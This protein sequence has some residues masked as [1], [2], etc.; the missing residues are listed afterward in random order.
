MSGR[1]PEKS[2]AAQALLQKRLQR[3]AAGAAPS[4][5]IPQRP[6]GGPAPVSHAQE[7][8]WFLDRLEPGSAAYNIPAAVRWHGRLRV[9]VLLAALGEIV[10]RHES[11]RTTF[12]ASESG[13]ALQVVSPASPPALPLI[14]L[15]ALAMEL[16]TAESGRLAGAEARAPFDLERGPLLRARLLRL[17]QGEEETEHVLLATLHHIVSDGWSQGLLIGELAALYGAFAAGRSSPLPE[18]T[19][20]YPDF[21]AWQR[22]WL[23]GEVLE[24]QLAYWRRQLAGAPSLLELPTDRPR[25]ALQ[26]SGGGSV[27]L[28]LPAGLE[29]AVAAL[30][31]QAGASPF[32]VLLA[33]FQALLGRVSGQEDVPVGTP[34]AGRTR[35]ETEPLIGLFMNTL[36][37][38]TDLSG[39]PGF[40]ELVG[41]VRETALEAFAHQDVPFEK[42]VEELRP[43]RNLAHSP[44]FQVMLILQNAPTGVV[45][46][47]DLSLSRLPVESGTAKLDLTLALAEGQGLRAQL[48]YRTDLFDRTTVLRLLGHFEVLLRA[49][50]A[51][52]GQRLSGLPLL[53]GPERQ[54]LVEWNDT[55]TS[56]PEGEACLHRLIEAQVER[57]PDAVAVV[58]AGERLT[59]R[60]LDRRANHL[61]WRLCEL[62]VEPEVPVGIYLDRSL[63][64][65]VALLA[66]WKAGG[67]YVPLDP[68]YPR[69][70]LAYMLDDSGAPVV[71]TEPGLLSTVPESAARAVCLE[72]GERA[73]GPAGPTHP[74]SLAYILYTSGSTGRPKGVQI[75]HGALVKFLESMRERPGLGVSDRLLAVT[76]LS[77]DIAG[78]ELFLPLLVGAEVEIAS[79]ET[80]ADGRRLL[81]RLDTATVLQ[82]TPSTWRLLLDSGWQGGRTLKAL[83]GGEALPP[84]L[85]AEISARAGSLWNMY[86]PT[87]T[88]IWSAVHR[89][90]SEAGEGTAVPLGTPI[91]NTT[92]HVVDPHLRPVPIGV[93]GEL[94]IG[95]AGLARG[96]FGRPDLTAER[97]IPDPFSGPGARLYRT[98]DLARWRA[99]GELEFLGRLDHQVKVRGHRIEL[100]EIEA[101][102]AR[103]ASVR[104]ALV[105][106]REDVPGD[107]RLTAFVVGPE[108]T[109]QDD[110]RAYLRAALPEYMVPAAFVILE[111]LPLLPNGKVDRKA[112]LRSAPAAIPR[113]V[114][115]ALPRTA[116]EREIAGIWREVLSL[117][118][119]GVQ[120]NFFDLGGHSLLLV[121]VQ[122]RLR[123]T[124]G[125]D[126]PLVDLFR[127]PTVASLAGYLSPEVSPE[128]SPE[129]A[130]PRPA[131][132]GSEIAVIGMAG[133]FP[134][135]AS[136]AELWRKLC[137]GVELI[138]SFSAEEGL[139]AGLPPEVVHDPR[140]VGARGVLEGPELFDA[141]F[142]DYTPREAQIMDP[143]QRV[144]LETAWQ[145]LEDAGY[146]GTAWPGR[147]GVY[148]GASE[149]LHVQNVYA[150]PEL[151]AA[152]GRYQ[153]A[154]ANKGDYLA[155]RVSYKM[156]L[157]GPSVNVQTACS[158]SLVAVHLACRSLLAGECDMALAGGVSVTALHGM[159]YLYEEG[160]IASPD[161]HCRAFDAGARG[162][163]DGDG[164]ALVVLKRLAD[165]LADG[166]RIDAVI[167]GSAINNDGSLKVGF[168]APSVEG[169]AEVIAAAQ[170]AAGVDPASIGYVEA[171]GT[172]TVLGDPIEI[173]ALTQAFGGQGSCA[174]GSV[175]T[176]VG[177]LD[178][179]AGVTGL[180][181]AVLAVKHG[182][183]PP[184]LHYETPNPMIDF[185]S[186]PFHV[187]SRLAEWRTDGAPRR[188]GVSSFGIGGTNAHAVVEEFAGAPEVATPPPRPW[189]LLLL[190]AKTPTALEAATANLAGHLEAS[191]DALDMA[192]V[193]YTLQAGRRALA[194]RR[195]LICADRDDTVTV[196]RSGDPERVLTRVHKGGAAP[197]A[198]LFPGQGS[199]SPGMGEGLHAEEPVFRE[200]L[201][202]CAELLRPEL[203]RDLLELLAAPA[204]ELARTALAQPALFAVEYALARLWMSWGVQ[205]QAMIG[206]SIGE[207]V[208]A[209]LAGVFSLE[210]GLRLVAARGLLMQTLPPGA[211]LGVALPEEEL[212]P[213][214]DGGLEIAVVNG[215]ADCVAAGPAA[216]VE[217]LRARL[218]ERGVDC[219]RLHTSHAFHSRMMDPAIAPFQRIVEGM[220]LHA[221]R[222]PYLSNITGTW[223]TAGE[224]TDPGYWARHLRQTVRFSEGVGE[225]LREPDRV[226]LEVG[227]GRS[228][229]AL[230]GRHPNRVAG[231]AVISSLRRPGDAQP[232]MPVLLAAAG[233]LWLAGVALDAEA[234]HAGRRHRRVALPTY[235]FERRRYWV[236]PRLRVESHAPAPVP[237][238]LPRD[239]D[240]PASYVEPRD[241]TEREVAGLWREALGIE[242]VGIF[243]DFFEVG[244]H[245]LMA[246]RL[247]S[248]L[249]D[250]F[251][252][253]VPID[254][255]F[256]A[257][258][259]AGLARQIAAASDGAVQPI[260]PVP[261]DGDLPLSFAQ[262]RLWFLTRLEPA[263]PWYNMPIAVRFQGPLDPALLERAAAEILRRHES[264]RTTF[265][266]SGGEPVQVVSP[267]WPFHLEVTGIEDSPDPFAEARRRVASEAASPFDLQLGPLWRLR[268]LRLAPE[269]HVVML[270]MH[271]IVSDGW[272]IGIFLSELTALYGA[273][274]RGE[275]PALPPLPVQYPDFAVWQRDW[276]SGDVLKAQLGYWRERLGGTLPVLELPLDRPRQPLQTFRGARLPLALPADLT[277]RLRTLSRGRGATLFMALLAAFKVLLRRYTGQEDLLVGVPIAGRNRSEI[278]GLIGFFVN[279][280]VLRTD[281][282]GDP[283]FEELLDRVRETTVGAY[284]HQDL[285]FERLVEELRPRRD[286]ARS[287]L[288]QVMIG[289]ENSPIPAGTTVTDTALALTPL[290]A[291]SGASRFEWTLFLSET[292]G[293]IGGSL[294]YNTDLFDEATVR[295]MA[296]HFENLLEAAA[297]DPA[298]S[299][300]RLRLLS[301]GEERQLLVEWNATARGYALDRPV[302]ELIAE[303]RSEAPAVTCEGETLS[304]AELDARANRLAWRLRD[305][306]VG[307][308]VPVGIYLER[309]LDLPVA[310]LAVWK[311]G[312]AYVPLDPAYPRERLAWM[313]EDSGAPVVLTESSLLPTVPESTALT[314]CVE[315]GESAEGPAVPVHPESLAYILYTSGSTG[316]PKGV[317]IPHGALVNFLESM[318]ERPGLDASDRLLAVTSLSFDIAGLELYLPLLAGAEVEIAG[319]ALAADGP[320]LLSR[321]SEA[322][323]LQATPSTWRLLLSAGW[324]GSSNLKALCGGEALPPKL[325][326]EIAARAG[327]LWNMYGPTETTIWSATRLVESVLGEGPVPLGKPIANTTIYMV[328]PHLRPVPAGVPGELLIGGAGLA[329]GYFG[330]P[331]LTAERF[332]PDPFA[333]DGTRLYRTG[334]L[335]RWLATGELEFLGRLDHQVKVRG[336]RI[337]LGEIEAALEQH[338]EV[339]AAVVIVREDAPGDLRL[340]AYVVG[341]APA[342]DL[343][344]HLRAKLPEYMVPSAFVTLQE[345]PLLPNGKVDRKALPA[346]E[347]ER[348]SLSSPF[349]APKSRLEGTISEAWR[350]VLGVER[351]GV[352]DN[353]FDLGGHSLLM[354]QVHQKLLESLPDDLGS[355][356]TM[357]ELFQYPTVAALARHLRPEASAGNIATMVEPG[358]QRA[359]IRRGSARTSDI[360]VVG[361]AGRFPGAADVEAFWRN[362]RDGVEAISRFSDE[363]LIASGIPPEVFRDPNYVNARGIPEGVGWFDAGFFGYTPREAEIIDPQHRMFLEVAWD[364]LENAACDPERFPGLIGVFAGV[365]LNTYL[366]NLYSNPELMAS[367]GNFQAMIGNDKDFLPTRVSYKLNLKGPSL[368]VQTACSTSLVAV[369]L[370]CQHLLHG[371]CDMALAGGVTL[372]SPTKAGNM[373]QEG[374]VFSPDGRCRAF[375]ERSQGT[376]VGNGSAV[377]VL[378]RLDDALAGGDSIYAVIKGSAINNDGSVKV[379]YTAPS[380]EGQT[381]VISQALAMAGVEPETIGYVEAHGTGTILGD[382]IEVRA[383]TQAFGMGTERKG[384][385]GIGSIKTNVGHMDT[386]AG[387]AGLIKAVL[388]VERGEIP[389]SLNFERPNPALGLAETPFYVVD[390]LTAW[391]S[392]GSPRRAGVSS[393][394]IGG[395][396]AH[397]VLEEAPVREPSGPSR[398]AQLLVLSARTEAALETA[399]DNL[400]WHLQEHSDLPL[401]DVAFTLHTGR[402]VFRHRRTV[403][404]ASSEEAAAL[405][406]AR[407]PKR[408]LTRAEEVSDRPVVFLFAGGGSQYPNMGLDLYRTEPVFRDQVD[409]CLRLLE[410]HVEADLRRHLFP[411]P[412]E[413]AE[414]SRLLERTSIALPVLFTIEYAQARLWMSWGV[415]PQAMLGH[416]LGEYVAACLAG[417][418]S[419]EDALAMV[420]LRGRLFDT[421]PEGGMLAVP[422]PEAEVLTLIGTELSIAAVN[423]PAFCVVSGLA[424]DIARAREMF[425]TRGVDARRLR[426]A[427][428]GHSS[429][430]APILREFGDFLATLSLSPP[431]IPYVS[432]VT[433]TW[434]TAADATDPSYWVRHLRQ[435]VRFG[436]GAGVLLTEGDRIFLEVGPGQT[437]S[438]LVMQHPDRVPGQTVLNSMRHPQDQ[439]S[440]V[441]FL[442]Q[443]LGKLWLGGA[444]VDWDGFH[445]GE[446]RRR[447]RLP[448]YP[449]ERQLYW[450]EPRRQAF[451]DMQRRAALAKRPDVADWFYVPSWRQSSPP[452]TVE[453]PASSWLL[454]LD[455]HG[456]GEQLAE[457]LREMGQQVTTADV[458]DLPGEIPDSIVHLGCVGEGGDGFHSLLALAKALADRGVTRPLRIEVVTTGVQSVTGNERIEPEKALV[459]GPVRVMPQEI[460]NVFCRAIDIELSTPIDRLAADLVSVLADPPPPSDFAVA[461]RGARRWV[462]GFEPVKLPAG[463]RS[464]RPGG[465]YLITGGLG[466]VGLALAEHLARAAN[467]RLV[468][469]GRSPVR[470][471]RLARLMAIEELGSEVLVA[472][473]DVRDPEALRAVIADA[474]QRFGAP[475]SGVIHAAGVTSGGMIQL[476]TPAAAEEVLSPKVA[477]TRALAAVLEEKPADEPPLDFLVLCSAI[478]S[479]L[480]GFGRVDFCA[481]SAFLDAFALERSDFT[482]SLGWDTWSETGQAA[483]SELPPDLEKVRRESLKHGMTT[484]EALEVFDRVLAAGLPRVV[485]STRD[486]APLLEQRR[487]AAPGEAAAEAPRPAA[488]HG[489]PAL[490]TAWVAPEGEREQAV[491]GIWEEFLGIQGIGAHDNFFELG[492][493][494]LMATQIASRMRATFQAEFTIAR[495]FEDPTVAG[496][497]ASLSPPAGGSGDSEQLSR[498]LEE[499]EGLSDEELDALL[500]AEEARGVE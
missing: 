47:G 496:L 233:R 282:S 265:A 46:L 160:G 411:A 198:F 498:L 373:Y 416:S 26:G 5:A 284:A 226:L 430:V 500:A 56:F 262:Q 458:S 225:L 278:E 303:R 290:E 149:N 260:R 85:A 166:D 234:M 450:V 310:L 136:V 384:F 467:V 349:L 486:L 72:A 228:L 413:M 377:V 43:Q 24:A 359:E 52:P 259:V 154:V 197:V 106:V 205:P 461:W 315:A 112:L 77:F 391:P 29:E 350:G 155:S 110:L 89:V 316:R 251:G 82:A 365:G 211:M 23:R 232:E 93:P 231:Q 427:A 134:G 401:A 273:F 49:A 120:D 249:R 183:I 91:A 398:D 41:R 164:A 189:H 117:P 172:G 424:E 301:A 347:A 64:L 428:A 150:S 76:S 171:H 466:G 13:E 441:G 122:R 161:G 121:R 63:D 368:N 215:P 250:H 229:S 31:R 58:C 254:A 105:L 252:V 92:I 10:R 399:T 451:A 397:V 444:A 479:V 390:R 176:N 495:F 326:G 217:E 344:R 294:E 167:K 119:V 423:G 9:P 21:A 169:Q 329:R 443:V 396:N 66:V 298:E 123:E 68:A 338:P 353:F 25:P 313:L 419:L 343:R 181:K 96:Y 184:S 319:R 471:D 426:I 436:D 481:A 71:L 327:S 362:L 196:L 54:Q 389:P 202:R 333:A 15:T 182:L 412:E 109:A 204:E 272:S 328:D 17:Q 478:N 492:G 179:A 445:A 39:E 126:L 454:L 230:A 348:P 270:T 241:A 156:D 449:F 14:D 388:A 366:V 361:M 32:M 243:D 460:E 379:G 97:F 177:H 235:P 275:E 304:Y 108:G 392:D 175:K 409:L 484:A 209:C 276:L 332:V 193:A 148:A 94:L 354:A 431:S 36:V 358:R 199:Q 386:A 142:F 48:E 144:L 263:S 80:A 402:K 288:F 87:E 452:R 27:A 227:P 195:M 393:F 337:E 405:L 191:G 457:R 474:R 367:V 37:L 11:L 33:A 51:D 98:G 152:A 157:K 143:Q 330:R 84:A 81:A 153:I 130:A 339:H 70:R 12:T 151:V 223:I 90:G 281:L 67:A 107:P 477:G 114:P 140:Y 78:L 314:V 277:E 414:A 400:A 178:A 238:A 341:P 285:P 499:V 403:V 99:D 102:L 236:E 309:S 418:M 311:A 369:H 50:V 20:Q 425:E 336:Y 274:A 408:V 190:S 371:E 116:A 289:L 16:G 2:A 352:H 291:D 135:A 306:G 374:N 118:A 485:V 357:L 406:A 340:T 383:L 257:P 381:A 139:A 55:R 222:I 62:G 299:L 35:V 69:E 22:D 322:T 88:T 86:G 446:R 463:S 159:G 163:V 115:S 385:C 7:R 370:A 194:H 323:V 174:I 307:P 158:T 317:Q 255:F 415:R 453:A 493:H 480:G 483:E 334:D 355:R 216:A 73:A 376:V 475:L 127:Y 239:E 53:A 186:G 264:L 410:P 258:T 124:L 468:L 296:G 447:L 280:L 320:R 44:L 442:L 192:D 346:P 213:L 351:V 132:E 111:A 287:P 394:G 490:S 147:I 435:T 293:G 292:S 434:M 248:R 203:G 133:L 271:H 382:P 162:T 1:S 342:G 395:T 487:S 75:P 220:D 439:Q 246:T 38:R 448:T 253:E 57:S 61:A 224:A 187:N 261:R 404:A 95:G 185:A 331:D 214:L 363:E 125:R 103:H 321:L 207:Y 286:L 28:D 433:G 170:A 440:D 489:R 210:D 221:P 6:H 137:A 269:D 464:V 297:G 129:R 417:V 268:A 145:A 465:V 456:I 245:S 335:A 3:K 378:K 30:S 79:R 59:Y 380:V 45:P 4:Q 312:G 40:R 201:D 65:P 212:L 356:L 497:A 421:L 247:V 462:Q 325:A 345:L 60:E 128:P 206:H 494:S 422:L 407:D 469:I 295:R 375:D 283:R 420:A 491:A 473:A 19:L 455:R 437:L 266:L 200:T 488:S 242:Q 432:N 470:K 472:S 138:A 101:V 100:G 240:V 141:A 364:A 302:H 476:K 308:E 324:Q 318:R 173:A 74:E 438:T 279:T 429:V 256:A 267:P 219:R 372:Y 237:E 244:G 42:L 18:L 131:A 113:G 208:A 104:A 83:C 305:L 459:L 165:A 8:L 168:T 482:V 34:V 387:T 146:G 360:A 300:S 188:A 218:A 180:I